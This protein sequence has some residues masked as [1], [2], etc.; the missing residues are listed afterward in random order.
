[1]IDVM[2]GLQACAA[3]LLVRRAMHEPHKWDRAGFVLL[4]CSA[5]LMTVRRVT[6]A[7]DRFI[8]PE[9]AVLPYGIA[10]TLMAAATCF[11]VELL[12]RFH[13]TGNIRQATSWTKYAGPFALMLLMS[14]TDF[15]PVQ[16]WNGQP[17]HSISADEAILNIVLG[18]DAAESCE[19]V[20]GT[21][22][23]GIDALRIL[24]AGDGPDAQI[25]REKLA[26][27]AAK[28]DAV[29]RSR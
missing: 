4:A 16:R 5:A 26:V 24:A 28:F 6:V 20:Q 19:I 3:G 21:C 27:L 7:L 15:V 10:W 9:G 1:M 25:A 8:L 29:Q 13:T 17:V 14:A 22:A 12:H 2:V 23:K 18:R 11:T